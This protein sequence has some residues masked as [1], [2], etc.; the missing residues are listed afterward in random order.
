MSGPGYGYGGGVG[1]DSR[2]G[3]VTVWP[4]GHNPMFEAVE[5]LG[6][7]SEKLDRI[8][9]ALMNRA[10]NEREYIIDL[11]P[12]NGSGAVLSAPG[13]ARLRNRW[14]IITPMT[15]GEPVVKVGTRIAFRGKMTSAGASLAIPWPEIIDVGQDIEF[16]D[17]LSG[18]T[19]TFL[20]WLVGTTE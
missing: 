3:E 9:D 13:H 18:S 8:A 10:M 6:T 5:R 12:S 7:I 19:T 4:E 2:G 16:Y 15:T 17:F 14:L 1:Q 11:L 20:G